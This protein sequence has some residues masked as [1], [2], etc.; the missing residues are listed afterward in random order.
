MQRAGTN[1]VH[2]LVSGEVFAYAAVE[3]DSFAGG[4]LAF[5]VS[6]IYAF[7]EAG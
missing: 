4:Q 7:S 3:T 1:L 2:F 6:L 5:V